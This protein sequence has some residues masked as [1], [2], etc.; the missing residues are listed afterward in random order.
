M[1]T[2]VEIPDPLFK[3]AR[4][5]AQE[6]NL[7]FREVV[8]AGLRKVVSTPDI[9]APSFRLKDRSFRGDGMMKDYSWQEIRAAVYE[10]RG[11]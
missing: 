6:H 3:E 2:T 7:T 5:F 10:G 4:R 8:E 1:K 9:A 11:E